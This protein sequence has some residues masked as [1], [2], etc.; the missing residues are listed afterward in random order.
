MATQV[1]LPRLGQGMDE[2]KVLQ[3]L[4]GEGDT[5]EKGDEL[6]EVETEKVNV[7]VEAPAG[8]TILKVLVDA[9]QT[10][11]IGTTLAWIGEAGES[12]PEET[13]D[14]PAE[15]GGEP[16]ARAASPAGAGA[17][18]GA[19]TSAPAEVNPD[20]APKSPQG[21]ARAAGASNAATTP[22]GADYGSA[23]AAP[24]ARGE[25]DRVKASPLARR[26]AAEQGV[27]LG[28]ITGSGPDG[29]IV[30]RDLEGVTGGAAAAAA[31]AA[32]ATSSVQTGEGVERIEL[33]SMRK[34]IARRLTEAW[35]A[36][37][38]FLT[39]D[40]DMTAANALRANLLKHVGEGDVR[41]TVS[42][43]LT[44]ASAVALR[45]N[46]EMNAHW[47]GDA[48]LRFEAAHVGLAVATDAGLVVPVI[49]DAH[50][51]TITEIAADRKRLVDK[52]RAGKLQPAEFEGGTFTISN[53]GMMG[54][55]SFTAVLNPPQAAILAVGATVDTPVVVDRRVEVRPIMTVT[56]T[57]DHRT[58][59]G[60]VGARF[61]E[62][63]TR[64]LEDPTSML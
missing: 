50:A 10:V 35:S 63:L 8:G 6:Y 62:S 64:H 18:S 47:A 17:P 41:P 30:A 19:D 38:F 23:T 40:I 45:R 34:T 31:P 11:E 36:P 61:L 14:A 46:R 9:G 22:T 13:G 33:T 15:S 3:W 51:K 60:A 16:A 29:R 42:D 20:S 58:V 55:D 12:V 24:P 26:M 53:L 1:K 43:I 59:D 48:I 57:C 39:K 2:G 49:R 7:E 27:E 37:A 56:L 4:K 54:V 25:G 28:S 44:K 52:A 21:G 5:I 32:A